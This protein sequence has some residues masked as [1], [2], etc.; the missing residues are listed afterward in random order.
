MTPRGVWE[1]SVK[2]SMAAYS[3]GTGSNGAE[4]DS[5]AASEH[6]DMSAALSGMCSTS[7]ATLRGPAAGK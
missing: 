3:G 7:R 2:S 1:L 5:A 4:M 6:S